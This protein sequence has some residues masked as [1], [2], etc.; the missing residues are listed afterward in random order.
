MDT[1]QWNNDVL[2]EAKNT[3]QAMMIHALVEGEHEYI[4]L[5]KTM[6]ESSQNVSYLNTEILPLGETLSDIQKVICT[7]AKNEKRLREEIILSREELRGYKLFCGDI[8]NTL[9]SQPPPATL[10]PTFKEFLM[11]RTGKNP[12]DFVNTLCALFLFG[13]RAYIVDIYPVQSYKSYISVVRLAFEENTTSMAM[14][15]DRIKKENSKHVSENIA[16]YFP[17]ECIKEERFFG[18]LDL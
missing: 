7:N 12:N 3:V 5:S 16:R 9:F 14:F 8:V 10:K 15:F 2:E 1:T 13:V 18:P 4:E 11:E 6:K 17:V